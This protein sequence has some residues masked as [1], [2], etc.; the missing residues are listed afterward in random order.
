[1]RPSTSRTPCQCRKSAG[2]MLNINICINLTL[3]INNFI[4]CVAPC[5]T[6]I[7]AYMECHVN[8]RNNTCRVEFRVEKLCFCG[9]SHTIGCGYFPGTREGQERTYMS[10]SLEKTT[11]TL[12][13]P[14][15]KYQSTRSL[16]NIFHTLPKG[17]VH[18]VSESNSTRVSGTTRVLP[19]LSTGVGRVTLS[20]PYPMYPTLR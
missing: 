13:I 3:L 18:W 10:P 12:S 7:H 19:G 2:H 6:P 5:S 20:I 14:Y 16:G 9:I 1:M 11:V 8:I 17:R 4:F 15:P